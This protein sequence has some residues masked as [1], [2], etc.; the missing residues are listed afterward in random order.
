VRLE[1]LRGDYDRIRKVT[2]LLGTSAR[3]A[4]ARAA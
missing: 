1:F 4:Q 3:P 2:V